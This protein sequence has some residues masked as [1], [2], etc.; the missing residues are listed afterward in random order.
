MNELYELESRALVKEICKR[1]SGQ[2]GLAFDV[3]V[4]ARISNSGFRRRMAQVL[5]KIGGAPRDIA[6]KRCS[7]RA[8]FVS[9]KLCLPE[10]S[11]VIEN[12]I[13]SIDD[14]V[15][16]EN[17]E[18]LM[19]LDHAIEMLCILG[20]RDFLIKQV[21]ALPRFHQ[22]KPKW[23][24]SAFTAL[25][26]LY[27]HEAVTLNRKYLLHPMDSSICDWEKMNSEELRRAVS[28]SIVGIGMGGMAGGGVYLN[29]VSRRYD[30]IDDPALRRRVTELLVEL[31]TQDKSSLGG[32]G[33]YICSVI[34][35]PGFEQTLLEMISE[36]EKMLGKIFGLADIAEVSSCL[37]LVMELNA[38]IRRLRIPEAKEFLV[39]QL[40][41]LRFGCALPTTREFLIYHQSALS[42]LSALRAVDRELAERYRP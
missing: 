34:P 41:G 7:G 35:V 5:C 6:L 17:Q 28:D 24:F 9:A 32:R 22:A 8:I 11:R 14:P 40:D 18:Y 3:E 1:L 30:F 29:F 23:V 13:D 4:Y 10:V 21:D 16:F 15:S 39:K 19:W 2:A 20:A 33:V 36:P 37:E 42:A 27:P 26:L 38:A 31:A 12:I 25:R